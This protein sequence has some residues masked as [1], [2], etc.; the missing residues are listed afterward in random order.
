MTEELSN[1]NILVSLGNA[2]DNRHSFNV[3]SIIEQTIGRQ[4]ITQSGRAIGGS[5][6]HNA[7]YAVRKK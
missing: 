1:P 4:L 5:S 6:E 7:M 3:A 2:T